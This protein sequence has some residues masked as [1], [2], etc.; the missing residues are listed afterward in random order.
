LQAEVRG[1]QRKIQDQVQAFS[2]KRA[3]RIMDWQNSLGV[4]V[5]PISTALDPVDQLIRFTGGGRR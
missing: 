1:T 5:L 4:P 2:D 3:G